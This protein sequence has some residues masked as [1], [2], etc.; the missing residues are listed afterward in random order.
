M[1]GT[2]LTLMVRFGIGTTGLD[3]YSVRRTLKKIDYRMTTN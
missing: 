2:T 3:G 1:A